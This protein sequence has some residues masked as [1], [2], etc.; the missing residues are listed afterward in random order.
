MG[1]ND[2]LIRTVKEEAKQPCLDSIVHDGVRG[3]C[4]DDIVSFVEH[5]EEIAESIR[6]DMS[7]R[8]SIISQIPGSE[9]LL[10]PT[11][12]Q[13]LSISRAYRTAAR[14]QQRP[15]PPAK[16]RYLQTTVLGRPQPPPAP[17]PRPV[18]IPPTTAGVRD[19]P[20]DLPPSTFLLSVETAIVGGDGSIQLTG[21]TEELHLNFDTSVPHLPLT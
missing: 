12:Q 2:L 15:V 4:Y 6:D 18:L 20:R 9:P 17:P 5:D 19:L 14:S 1:Q 11:T 8:G 7:E 10:D 13:T 21:N 16:P 3:T